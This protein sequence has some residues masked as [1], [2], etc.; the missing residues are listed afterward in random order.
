VPE[1]A[2]SPSA[3]DVFYRGGSLGAEVQL[4]TDHCPRS[5]AYGAPS[6]CPT[7]YSQTFLSRQIAL[8][9]VGGS[10]YSSG[11]RES[12]IAA[13]VYSPCSR[14]L[15]VGV[16]SSCSLRLV[17]RRLLLYGHRRLQKVAIKIQIKQVTRPL[18]MYRR[19]LQVPSQ[20]DCCGV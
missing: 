1:S 8:S 19:S 15:L 17:L 18:S 12:R 5:T 10:S 6:G 2:S 9:P 14:R 11:S 20:L 4:A 16:L 13:A 7:H 3:V